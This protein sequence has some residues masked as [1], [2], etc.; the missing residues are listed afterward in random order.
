VDDAARQ[1]SVLRDG[2]A[3]LLGPGAYLATA[4][5]GGCRPDCASRP[6]AGRPGVF[7][8]TRQLPAELGRVLRVQIDGVRL[9]VYAEF[10]GLVGWAASQIV[11]QL[12][13]DPLHCIPPS[14]RLPCLRPGPEISGP[15]SLIPSRCA[16]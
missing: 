4:L 10:H 6:R 13:F 16:V 11:F 9:A 15:A 14:C 12:H 8:E 7:D 3:M 2:E 1:A 5:P